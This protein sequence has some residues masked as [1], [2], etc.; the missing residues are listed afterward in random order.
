MNAQPALP[1][2]LPVKST[3]PPP[4]GA[5]VALLPAAVE[6]VARV[7]SSLRVKVRDEVI[8]ALGFAIPVMR[9]QTVGEIGQVIGHAQVADPLGGEKLVIRIE[10]RDGGYSVVD[11]E[12]FYRRRKWFRFS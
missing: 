1:G 12:E 5:S 3:F 6:S 10:W 4:V 9:E 7:G 8:P 11:E 2:L